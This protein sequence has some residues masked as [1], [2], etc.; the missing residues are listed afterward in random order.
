MKNFSR[1]LQSVLIL[2]VLCF[3]ILALSLAVSA[4]KLASM[5]QANADLGAA[6][7]FAQ[8]TATPPSGGDRSEIG[9]TDGIVIMGVVIVMIVVVPIL[10]RRKSWSDT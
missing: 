2:L 1:S 10:L 7:F 3:L 8:S 6:A 5:P 4:E 9:S